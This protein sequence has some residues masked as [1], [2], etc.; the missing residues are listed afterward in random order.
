[1]TSGYEPSPK[2]TDLIWI[3]EVPAHAGSL[4]D[5][6]IVSPGM[7]NCEAGCVNGEVW[8][9]SHTNE[10][11]VSWT[12]PQPSALPISCVS[13]AGSNGPSALFRT[14]VPVPPVASSVTS[15]CQPSFGETT[16][17]WMSMVSPACM[18]S[19]WCLE[20]VVSIAL[21]AAG[22]WYTGFC[23]VAWMLQTGEQTVYVFGAYETTKPPL[24]VQLRTSASG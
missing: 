17:K 18:T 6:Q 12:S 8:P 5:W 1:M 11:G 15:M 23:P 14:I 19:G 22:S 2:V 4:K 21:K 3:G 24:G 20:P 9:I 13:Y 7:Q 16:W 10:F